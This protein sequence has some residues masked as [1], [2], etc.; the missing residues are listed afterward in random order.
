MKISNKSNWIFQDLKPTLFIPIYIEKYRIIFATENRKFS[1][2]TGVNYEHVTMA[3]YLYAFVA[4]TK[5]RL[6]PFHRRTI[7]FRYTSIIQ[8]VFFSNGVQHDTCWFSTI[9]SFGDSNYNLHFCV[10]IIFLSCEFVFMF[11]LLFT[12]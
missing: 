10:L 9:F 2:K 12:A 8:D 11:L 6:W 3:G 1:S 5:I 7:L 4:R